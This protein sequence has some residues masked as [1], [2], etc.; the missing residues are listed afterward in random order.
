MRLDQRRAKVRTQAVRIR[1][2][3]PARR[4]PWHALAALAVACVIAFGPIWW[5]PVVHSAADTQTAETTQASQPAAS[6]PVASAPAPSAPQGS[7]SSAPSQSAR[8]CG[9]DQRTHDGNAFRHGMGQRSGRKN[10]RT[11]STNCSGAS[12]AA[13]WPPSEYSV[14][15]GMSCC[16]SISRRT[17]DPPPPKTAQPRGALG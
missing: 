12:S 1:T 3:R 2:T 11:S 14:Q 6:Q 4:N 7:Q 17:T 8:G 5:L 13:K 10:A 15:C 9:L 16:G